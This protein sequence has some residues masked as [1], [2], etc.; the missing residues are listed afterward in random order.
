M[1]T[2]EPAA[3]TGSVSFN[4]SGV[5]LGSTDLVNGVASLTWQ[6]P[7]VA[8]GYVSATYSGDTTFS[9]SSRMLPLEVFG[10]MTTTKL[11]SSAGWSVE[12]SLVRLTATLDPP[13]DS[14][15]VAF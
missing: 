4:Y 13:L 2:V 10:R 5:L 9:Q 7:V 8:S 15:S 11:V 3:A 6:S 1:A 12:G 14:A